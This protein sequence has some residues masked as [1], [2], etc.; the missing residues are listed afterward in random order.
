MAD[1]ESKQI[2]VIIAGRGYPL[3]IKEN[4]EELMIIGGGE[5]Y[6]STFEKTDKIIEYSHNEKAWK[7]NVKGAQEISYQKYAFGLRGL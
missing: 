3:K 1:E 2:S 6:K 4:E 7:D 5:I